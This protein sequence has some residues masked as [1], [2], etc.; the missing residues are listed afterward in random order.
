[1]GGG[2]RYLVIRPS[3]GM[4]VYLTCTPAQLESYLTAGWV[5]AE[6]AEQPGDIVGEPL[7]GRRMYFMAGPSEYYSNINQAIAGAV[8]AGAQS[9][10]EPTMRNFAGVKI[11]GYGGPSSGDTIDIYIGLPG[12]MADF[13][14]ELSATEN[15]GKYV[16]CVFPFSEA[17]T[18]NCEAII[19]RLE[20]ELDGIAA[21]V[22]DMHYAPDSEVYN[23]C[24]IRIVALSANDEV[25]C[26]PFSSEMSPINPGV[27]PLEPETPTSPAIIIGTPGVNPEYDEAE[28]EANN[29]TVVLMQDVADVTNDALPIDDGGGE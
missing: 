19:A 14:V 7:G 3:D 25:L 18:A 12:D 16:L 24:D 5:L 23:Y 29:I 9:G 6:G 15:S 17:F 22:P 10:R 1:M 20:T 4:T 13:G 2:N 27:M 28:A 11:N 21:V 26:L 8:A